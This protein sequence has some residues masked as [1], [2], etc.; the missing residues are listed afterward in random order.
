MK[1]AIH[2]IALLAIT[3]LL[4][5]CNTS[6]KV[7]GISKTATH[8]FVF[9]DWGRKGKLDQQLVADQ[10]RKQ[11]KKLNPTFVLVTGDN[12][13]EEGVKDIYDAH[14]KDSYS[15][16]YK[17]LSSRYPW[18]V[19]LGNHDYRGN[20][21]AEIDFHGVNKQWNM[22]DRYY[23][24]V[25]K[26][27]DGQDIRL[28]CIDT[29]PWY[30]DYYTNPVMA[31]V[32][33]QDTAR[34]RKWIDSTLANA[35]EPWK[36]VFGHHP[37]YSAAKRGGTPELISML[38]PMLEKYKVQAYIC[39]HDHN[40]QHY[41]PQNSYVDYVISG[42]GSEVKDSADFNKTNF[43]ASKPGFA[44]FIIKGDSLKMNFIDKAG[45]L[46]YHFERSR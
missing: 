14:W 41:H 30:S 15:D 25:I 19:T 21:Q 39:G 37:V 18:Y 45:N 35:K 12:F 46:L 11:A 23:T 27:K 34:Q 1:K 10:M 3:F 44:D 29:S 8:F 40:L 43:A 13:Y 22:P 16:V 24:E 42:G 36:F 31:G 5:K 38:A 7:S 6:K 17:E 26:T 33:S 2:F 32:K 9:G 20:P 28:I 4:V